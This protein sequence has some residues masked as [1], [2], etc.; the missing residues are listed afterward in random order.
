MRDLL[1]GLALLLAAPLAAGASEAGSI[2]PADA[3]P[4]DRLASRRAAATS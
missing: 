2:L 1:I 3:D 4:G